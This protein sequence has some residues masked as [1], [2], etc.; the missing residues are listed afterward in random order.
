MYPDQTFELD[1]HEVVLTEVE[2]SPLLITA[3]VTLK[4]PSGY[5]REAGHEILD[6]NYTAEIVAETKAG[7]RPLPASFGEGM[8]DSFKKMFSSNMLDHPESLDL[9]FKT[10]TGTN[11]EEIRIE[12]LN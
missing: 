6:S 10:G 11:E 1:G 7:N 8:K 3:T 2:L 5:Q 4:N 12:I 9:V